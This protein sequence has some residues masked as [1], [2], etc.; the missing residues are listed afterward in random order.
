MIKQT[1]NKTLLLIGMLFSFCFSGSAQG[2]HLLE[3][4]EKDSLYSDV[5]GEQREFWI[6]LP[7]SYD[8]TGTRKYP[9]VYIL[10]GAV[11][12][13]AV[14]TVHTYY[15]GGFMPEMILIG[16]SNRTHRTRDLT[17]S[18]IYS[19][20]GSEYRQESGGA[21]A[22]TMFLEK[23]LFPF[24]ESKYPA[25]G[26]RS[27]IAHSYGGLFAIHTLIHHPDLF[28]NYLAIDP[29]LDWDN[30]KLLKESKEIL[31]SKSF[32]GKSLFMSL[33][34]QLHMQNSDINLKNVMQDT[35]EYTLFARSSIEFSNLV[36]ETARDELNFCWKFYEDD[37]H[38]TIVLPSVLDG[39]IYLFNWYPIRN[40]DKFNSPDTPL[41]ELVDIIRSREKR[42]KEH[43]GY[44]EPPFDEELLSMLGYMNLEWGEKQKSLAFF[45]L[46]IE[47]FPLSA[48]AYDSLADYYVA[49]GDFK[50]ALE[51]VSIAYELSGADFH[52]NRMEELKQK[53]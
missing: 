1:H 10:D 48:N 36:N 52:K 49:Q 7:E 41:D 8:P 22:F 19:R 34:G 51:N 53:I 26:Y 50:N 11:H 38:G 35:S 20:R 40:T 28:A 33:G 15:W 46:C 39:M 6:Q 31:G 14:S 2:N 12:F 17:P 9:V 37:L 23:E 24:I 21:E 47:Y 18:E 32:K 27:L 13:M 25:T 29:S 5:L 43:F 42:L 4:G 16:I 3:I 45:Q 44:F 30:Q